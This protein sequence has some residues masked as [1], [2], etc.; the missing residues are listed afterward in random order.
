MVKR[1]GMVKKRERS[2]EG[3]GEHEIL[4]RKRDRHSRE[5]RERN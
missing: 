1:D 2:I 5:R 4:E 3:E